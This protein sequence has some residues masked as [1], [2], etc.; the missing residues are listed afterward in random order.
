MEHTLPGTAQEAGV[1]QRSRW[2]R[3]STEGLRR[4]C[5]RSDWSS[6]DGLVA[7]MKCGVSEWQSSRAISFWRAYVRNPD[8]RF[9]RGGNDSYLLMAGY[10][11][12]LGPD[13][14]YHRLQTQ[15]PKEW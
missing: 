14:A 11:S 4:G 5:M 9:S 6:G 8:G 2:G 12:L 15:T 3:T 13:G 1:N 7:G 10:E